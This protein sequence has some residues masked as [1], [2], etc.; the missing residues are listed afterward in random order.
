MEATGDNKGTLEGHFEHYQLVAGKRCRI[1][2]DVLIGGMLAFR[3]GESVII[4][5]VDPNPQ[6]PENRFVVTSRILTGRRFQ[7]RQEDLGPEEI[8]QTPVRSISSPQSRIRW[9]ALIW[10]R[11]R[12]AIVTC[13][14]LLLIV[15][16]AVILIAGHRFSWRSDYHQGIQMNQISAANPEELFALG[17][18]NID[19]RLFKSKGSKWD[20]VTSAPGRFT[21]FTVV[22][23]K[24]IWLTHSSGVIYFF[25]GK[26]L[27]KQLKASSQELLSTTP[28]TLNG[29]AATDPSHVWAVGGRRD[30][31]PMIGAFPVGSGRLGIV[32]FFNGKTWNVQKIFNEYST[33]LTHIAAADPEH[34]WATAEGGVVYFFDGKIWSRQYETD[35]VF[36]DIFA[37]DN[38]HVWAASFNQERFEGRI[39]L[40]NGS[41]WKGEFVDRMRF[42]EIFAL[43]AA[44]AWAGGNWAPD[45]KKPNG[46]ILLHYEKNLW[47]TFDTPGA[48]PKQEGEPGHSVSGIYTAAPKKVW[49]SV[50]EEIFYGSTRFW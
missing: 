33:E 5:T 2:H 27:D 42:D 4:D 44:E 16:V 7:L 39:F 28:D 47:K 1:T 38:T 14:A 40:F 35:G 3:A 41:E 17:Y 20:E 12:L 9:P 25:D 31:S 13:G 18:T 10:D 45:Q 37:L 30:T 24:H 50:G 22:D 19:S 23:S 48:E 43:N 8:S 29:I 6:R 36:D 34:V 49:V 11:H 26:I 32:Y 15:V 21:D 46:Q